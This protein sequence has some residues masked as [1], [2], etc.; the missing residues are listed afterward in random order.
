MSGQ[1]VTE[2]SDYGLVGSTF[3]LS[4]WLVLLS[5]ILFGGALLGQILVDFPIRM[6]GFARR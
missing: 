4:V 3:V 5:G 6:L 1:I 2:V